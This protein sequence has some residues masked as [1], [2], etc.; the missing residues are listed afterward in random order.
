MKTREARRLLT[1]LLETE[2]QIK[3]L[4]ELRTT[5]KSSL[6]GFVL[7]K[8]KDTSKGIEGDKKLIFN[9]DGPL[10]KQPIELHRRFVSGHPTWKGEMVGVEWCE[11]NGHK[12][13]LDQ[14]FIIVKDKWNALKQLGMVPQEIINLT[15]KPTS[16]RF[17]LYI[18]PLMKEE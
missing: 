5:I 9:I 1:N 12:S 10:G 17:D 14:V 18:T 7:D 6:S 16:D 3:E 13:V 2:K 15:E 8:G 11:Q 4:T